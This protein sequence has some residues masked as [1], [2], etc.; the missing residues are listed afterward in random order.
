M[1]EQK[2]HKTRRF[3]VANFL[4][5]PGVNGLIASSNDSNFYNIMKLSSSRTKCLNSALKQRLALSHYNK[6]SYPHVARISSIVK[7]DHFT[8]LISLSL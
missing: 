3:L 7:I 5:S 6:Y 2:C 4:E 1:P 8:S